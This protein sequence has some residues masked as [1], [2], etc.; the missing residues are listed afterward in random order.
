MGLFNP[1]NKRE[2]V[3]LEILKAL[4]QKLNRTSTN[5][6]D[7]NNYITADVKLAFKYADIFLKESETDKGE[8]Q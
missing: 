6:D 4:S 2:E 8:Q 7:Y 1:L 5:V 3:A